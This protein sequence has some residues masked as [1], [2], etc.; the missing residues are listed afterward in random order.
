MHG[1]SARNI[2]KTT[3]DKS[4]QLRRGDLISINN[5]NKQELENLSKDELIEIITKPQNKKLRIVIVDETENI[6][7]PPKMF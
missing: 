3:S 1:K 4:S 5:M 7:K 2:Q 6:I